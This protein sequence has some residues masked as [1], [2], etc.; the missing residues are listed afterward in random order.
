MHDRNGTAAH[1]SL[2]YL[3]Y[4]DGARRMYGVI[5]SYQEKDPGAYPALALVAEFLPWWL[6]A[7]RLRFLYACLTT[8]DLAP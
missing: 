5:P 8:A 2:R 6:R 4:A 1:N 7:H 3:N